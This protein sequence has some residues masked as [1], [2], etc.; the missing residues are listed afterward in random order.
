MRPKSLLFIFV[1]F[2]S[3]PAI[4]QSPE[5]NLQAWSKT[6]PIEKLYLQVDR[7][8]YTA[9]QTIWFSGYFLSN[10]IPS[11]GSTS[12]YTELLS[13]NGQIVIRKA[14]PAYLSKTYGQIDL[15]ETLVSGTYQL[16]AYSK[17]MLNQSGF[18]FT[19]KITVYGK[20]AVTKQKTTKPAGTYITFFP[21]GGN[22]ISSLL[23]M[24]AFKAVDE[25]GF[26][27]DVSLQITDNQ[28]N[29]ITTAKTT[30]DGMG[31]FAII[32]QQNELYYATIV[33]DNTLKQYA[34]PIPT[35]QGVAFSV[36]NIAN[37]KSFKITQLPGNETFKAAYM[38][39]QMQNEIVFKQPFTGNKNAIGGIIP[40][41]ELLSGILQLT[42]FNKD[43]MPLAERITFIDNKEYILPATFTAD[44]VNANTRQ[45]NH[46]S[47]SLPDTVIGNF[48]IAVTD[49]D[50]ETADMREQNIFSFFLLNS[51]L[52]GYIHNPAWYFLPDSNADKKS[53]ALDLVMMTNG[54]TRFKWE[55]AVKNTL[56][57]PLYKDNGFITM[58]GRI[59]I[60]GR[61]KLFANKELIYFMSPR[62]TTKKR[63]GMPKFIETDSAGN[64]RVDS[65]VFFGDMNIL[66]SDIKGSKSKYIKVT[67]TDDSLYKRYNL[68]QV[69]IPF[70]DTLTETGAKLNEEYAE[71]I[72]AEGLMLDAV[73]VK[74]RVKS[75]Q[76]ELDE[77]YTSGMFSG[78]INSRILDLTNEMAVGQYIF[79]YLQGRL[80]GINVSRDAEGQYV[81]TYRSGGFGGSNVTLYLDEMQTD[82]TF[83]ESIPVNQ[84]A[85]VKLMGNFVGAP[86]GGTA[87]AIYMKKGAE[88]SAVT[89]S[90]TDI[91]P[92]T[93]YTITKEFY[94]PDYEV[95]KPIDNKADN[96][97]TLHWMPLIYAAHVN[98]KIPVIF[99]NND[100][101]KRF[102]IVAEGVTND[103]RFL[104]IEQ[105]VNP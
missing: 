29:V 75:K 43:G 27:V 97:I 102:K 7:N 78:G 6:N 53:Q 14:F 28:K 37:G 39:G 26:P 20:N 83:I 58:Q 99:Y 104:M 47:I 96:R 87:L 51:D 17:P 16:R 41:G 65:M 36:N 32:P 8:S 90:A 81:L 10:F 63:F 48:S 105:I 24:V 19:K 55:D 76:E 61:K 70:K 93:G 84:I 35:H 71:Y 46:F 9:G 23:N 44:T 72:K 86:G 12:L 68:P 82:A 77:R 85:F 88:L 100:R 31:Y 4:S 22:L 62:D 30:H 18:Y 34:L 80:P 73:T 54:W 42:V 49:A 69:I 79:D 33:N 2:I 11:S 52:K 45:R 101:T 1:F 64:F 13:E 57:K 94:S 60:E 103:G 89:E 38:V 3:L 50:Y 92:Y 67:L 91:I 66:F 95:K 5:T 40:T 21:E 15:P 25:N 59:N 98:A 74:T 56:P